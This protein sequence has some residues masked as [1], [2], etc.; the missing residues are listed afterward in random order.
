MEEF[1]QFIRSLSGLHDAEVISLAWTPAQAEIRMS[2]KD[3]NAGWGDLPKTPG[4]F[5]FS[6]VTD[7][8]WAVDRPDARLK[9]Y[10]WE[11]V[12]IAGGHRSE[13]KISPSGQLVI[14]CAAIVFEPNHP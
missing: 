6:G 11:V 13:I 7:V 1:A 5:V 14:Q 12:P 8:E 10:D 9:I 3:I 4:V 2:I